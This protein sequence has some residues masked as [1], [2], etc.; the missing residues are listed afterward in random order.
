MHV[1]LPRLILTLFLLA[2]L[3]APAQKPFRLDTARL[4]RL[5]VAEDA[6]GTGA[7]GLTPL[8]EGLQSSDT[9]LRRVAV[10]GVGRLQRP[11]LAR[12]LAVRLTDPVAAIRAEAGNAIAQSVSRASRRAGDSGQVD[13]RWGAAVLAG[14]LGAE[15]DARVADALAEALGRLPF[16]DRPAARSAESAILARG[17]AGFG[18]VHGLYWLAVNR[19]TTGG[20][21]AAAITLLRGAARP[22]T[23]ATVRQVAILALTPI[24]GL[25]SAVVFA[26]RSDPDEQ[27]RRLAL[28][29]VGALSPAARATVV[30]A[31]LADKSPIVRI[32]AVAAA[33]MGSPRPDCA[34]LVAATT[35]P[36]PYVA[37]AA[38]DAL[39]SPCADSAAAAM[40]LL[41][42]LDES[43]NP[44]E[45]RN[46]QLKAHALVALAR[47]DAA[48]AREPLMSRRASPRSQSRAY[49]A[50]TAVFV[51]D[52]SLLL[53]L[54]RDTDNNVREAAIAGLSGLIKH[55]ADTVF[56]A[57]LTSSGY[58]V[59]LA[60]ANALAGSRFPA[61]LS[62]LLDAFDRLSGERRENARDP[63]VAVLKLISA[64]GSSA[65]AAR[66]RPYLADFDTTIA[67]SVAA[68]LS[69]WTDTAVAVRPV[70]LPIHAEP[71]ARIFLA[72]NVQLKVT[73][74]ASSGGG[75]FTVHLFTD[76]APAT[77]AR[78]IRLAR[79]HYYDG[80][81]FQRVEPNF[82]VQGGGPDASEY[83]GDAAFMRDEV[84]WHSHFRGTLGI[85][86]RGRD[87]GD[88]QWFF[89]LVDNT[90]LDHDYTVFGQVAT[91]LNVVERILE[92]D[93]I[94]RVEVLGAP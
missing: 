22:P 4:Q 42:I 72:R 57:G 48:R 74:A 14:A 44:A 61:A 37:L 77:A 12:Q 79:E 27:V 94:G 41:R 70:P 26:A 59:V 47:I 76:E 1:K 84:A 6:R 25:D 81:V 18:V 82:V 38:I 80:H 29:G 65:N 78:I 21:S 31:A 11:D 34:P 52:T 40:T 7:D 58:Q 56:V 69:K 62:A 66:L 24:S 53:R 73:M 33:R 39:G 8:L 23:D 30:H 91:G 60:S 13:V 93:V 2:P 19:G 50:R 51:G 71:L 5:L 17:G 83:V 75:T 9:M 67:T 90:R 85:S 45:E 87:T 63:R 89:N 54:A 32:A 92:G 35:D 20:L 86:T 46:W 68:A 16:G 64:M 43:P 55:A 36:H 28:A 10:R 88:A 3:A 49:A 15:R